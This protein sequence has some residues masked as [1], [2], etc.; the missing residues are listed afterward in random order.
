MAAPH[1]SGVA[2]LAK[3][4][5]P[6]RTTAE[7]RS[8][9]LSNVDVKASLD[10]KVA[11]KGRLN[12]RAALAAIAPL[13][14]TGLAGTA[15]GQTQVNLT[16]TDNSAGETGYE[17]QR[18]TGS[19]SFAT[20]ANLAANSTSHSDPTA[21]E[22]TAYTYRVR[23][24][25]SGASSGFSSEISVTTPPAAPSGLTASAAS[26]SGINLAR[27]DNSAG[28]TG[29]EIQRKTGTG[30]FLTVTTTAASATSYADSGLAA[31]TTYT[32]RVRA[33]GT[34]GNSAFSAEASATTIA[35]G[36]GGGGGG[37]GGGC[38]IATAAF[39][40]PLAAEVRVLREFRD[41]ALLTNA[42][43]QILVRIYYRLS[44]SLARAIA[45]N[46]TLRAA[47]RGALRPVIWWVHLALASPAL[48]LALS[49]GTLVASPIAAWLLLH[50]RRSRAARRG[51]K[52]MP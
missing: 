35:G 52:V 21:S 14:P 40:S 25:N 27:T 17:V 11:T 44:P 16:W 50:A 32:Y 8:A 41:R 49:G 22:A 33:T 20:L 3:A 29:Y 34:G 18:K 36:S 47:T 37:G 12:A 1:V 6:N 39:G 26:A 43:G 19:G 10:G 5:E 31:T 13:A 42:P 51:R 45:A 48:A 7:I 2:A 15:A 38:F 9:I 30:A 24:S 28:E 46:G 23:A 4:Q